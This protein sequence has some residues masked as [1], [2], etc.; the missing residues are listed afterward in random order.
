MY[1]KNKTTLIELKR[2]LKLYKKGQSILEKKLNVLVFE[3]IKRLKKI[4]QYRKELQPIIKSMYDHYFKFATSRGILYSSLDVLDYSIKT[5][6]INIMGVKVFDLES[7]VKEQPH[8][9]IDENLK[10][11]SEELKKAIEIILKIAS[12]EDAVR[13]LLVEIGKTKRKK[14]YLE[15]KLIPNVERHIKEIRQYLDDEERETII[16]IEKAIQERT[17]DN[18]I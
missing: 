7:N 12:E 10:K 16:R 3:L 4:K 9:Y 17:S 14:L 11:A 5:K 13:K 2:K 18:I 1:A 8:Y 6:T 15:K